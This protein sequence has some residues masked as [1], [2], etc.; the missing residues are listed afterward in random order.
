MK[1]PFKIICQ[2]VEKLYVKKHQKQ[3]L[4]SGNIADNSKKCLVKTFLLLKRL[5][6]WPVKPIY[7]KPNLQSKIKR[8][9][10]KKKR[11]H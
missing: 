8:R 3:F 4:Q 1:I 9:K 11:I 10:A 7:Y 2:E 6:K 5:K